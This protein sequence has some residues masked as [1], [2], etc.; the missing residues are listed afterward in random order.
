MSERDETFGDFELGIH[1]RQDDL[2]VLSGTRGDDTAEW[3]V[4]ERLGGIRKQAAAVMKPPVATPGVPPSAA[5]KYLRDISTDEKS[6]V[7]AVA[8]MAF[9]EWSREFVHG[10]ESIVQIGE[11]ARI[12]LLPDE[13]FTELPRITWK[14][15][16][17]RNLCVMA[18]S[19]EAGRASILE[20]PDSSCDGVLLTSK[21]RVIEF[22]AVEDSTPIKLKNGKNIFAESVISERPESVTHA[23]VDGYIFHLKPM[24]DNMRAVLEKYPHIRASVL[25]ELVSIAA[26]YAHRKMIKRRGMY[27]TDR[28]I[29]G[30][31]NM[32]LHGSI[33]DLF[34]EGATL[35]FDLLM[36]RKKVGNSGC[37]LIPFAFQFSGDGKKGEGILAEKILAED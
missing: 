16:I 22:A 37:T 8:E 12:I 9:G 23:G 2:R 15:P 4:T 18:Q 14:K 29:G 21:G 7:S 19:R 32:A 27:V 3:V 24:P 26:N 36:D 6:Y 34:A 1:I 17:T 25:L 10:S 28:Y 13:T 20:N 30:C 11:V 35:K 5:A 33:E 31:K